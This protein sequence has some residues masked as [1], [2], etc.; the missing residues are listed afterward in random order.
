MKIITFNL[1]NHS[2]RWEE[3]F[4]LVVET[5]LATEADLIAFQE[6]SLLLGQKNQ[7]ELIADALHSGLGREMYK[8]FLAEGRGLQKG[9]E[10]IAILS[11]LPVVSSE[12]IALPGKWRVAQ[13][14]CIQMDGREVNLFNTHLHHKPVKDE[15][16]RFPQAEKVLLWAQS[17]DMPFILTGDMNAAPESST[18]QFW[19]ASLIS[20]FAAVN[21]QEPDRTWPTPLVSK[22]PI[23]EVPAT[24]D[25]I[26]LSKGDFDVQDSYLIGNSAAAEDPNLYPSDHFGIYAEVEFPT[27][28]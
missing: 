4:P 3:R 13:K 14:V 2:D 7:A 16:I 18:I 19:K 1:R 9:R 11:R 27:R 20:A 25:Y 23:G 8:V 5:L 12:R 17:C 21:D 24:L 15:S 10:G 28:A 6:V 22:M 26:F